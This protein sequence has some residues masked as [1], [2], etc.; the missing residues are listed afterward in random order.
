MLLWVIISL[1]GAG[2]VGLAFFLVK[3]MLQPKKL[4]SISKLIKQQKF[5]AAQKVAKSMI[6][7]NPRDYLAHYYLGKAYLADKKNELALMEYKLVNQNAIFG[8]EIPETEFRKQ[9]SQLYLKFNQSEDAL[10]EFL[11]LTKL[12]PGNAENYYMC[13]KIYEQKNRAEQALGFFQKAIKY[14]RKHVKAHAAMGLLLFRSKQFTEAKK[15][16]DLAISL[17]PETF[18]SYYYLGKIL[19]ESKD[20]SGAVKAFEKALRDPEFKQRAYLERGSC[21]MMANSV[22]N[23]MAEFEKAIAASKDERSQETLYARY[24]LA[25]CYEKNRNIDKAIEQWQSI[26]QHNHSFRDVGAKLSEYK[27]LQSNDSLK[28]FLT[29]SSAEFA[30]LCKKA[31]L[32]G[33]SMVAQKIDQKKW[34]VQMIAVEQK[35]DD[36]MN[37]RKQLYLINFYRDAE[38]IEDSEIRRVLDMAKSQNCSKTY[39]CSSA[40]FTSSA[41]GFAENR[42]I[43]LIGKEKLERILAKA[44]I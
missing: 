25:A 19:K 21:Y 4:D 40:G 33:M 17:S 43:E 31:A 8:G 2:V 12:D 7:K 30:E 11:L 16:I 23:A 10:K 28:E 36:W 38:P 41:S 20:Y 3:S 39:L 9:L 32:D 42:P 27:D 1:L 44:G 13:G 5:S 14:N 34:G 18:S 37:V 24:F 26:Y 35:K 6:A 15:E 29:C 22:D